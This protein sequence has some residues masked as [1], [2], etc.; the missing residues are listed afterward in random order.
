MLWR[1]RCH[2]A[3][4][5]DSTTYQ[6]NHLP[7]SGD[8]CHDSSHWQVS[9]LYPFL[10]GTRFPLSIVSGLLSPAKTYKNLRFHCNMFITSSGLLFQKQ[11]RFSPFECWYLFWE[12]ECVSTTLMKMLHQRDL[13]MFPSTFYQLDC[14]I[15][16][17]RNFSPNRTFISTLSVYL[18]IKKL[19]F[20]CFF[21]YFGASNYTY[22]FICTYKY[23]FIYIITDHIQ[24]LYS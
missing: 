2:R 6:R 8:R 23:A 9:L 12:L 7:L 3:L 18:L 24:L 5:K 19:T 21:F 4:D 10:V 22:L 15:V 1:T 17:I 16:A 20:F 14:I 11:I 13:N